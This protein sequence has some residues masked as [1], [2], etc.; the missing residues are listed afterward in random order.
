[1]APRL[2]EANNNLDSVLVRPG[3]GT[4]GKYTPSKR[5]IRHLGPNHKEI[6]STCFTYRVLLRD[7][8]DIP[9]IYGLS[10]Y[11]HIPEFDRWI[12]R[13]V[14]PQISYSQQLRV[15]L[16]TLK[17]EELP[18]ILK[19][20]LQMLVYNGELSPTKVIQL[21]PYARD[22]YARKDEEVA[23]S[24]FQLLQDK[25]SYPN[26]NVEKSEVEIECLIDILDELENSKLLTHELE[27]RPKYAHE[28]QTLIHR[29]TVSPTGIYLSGPFLETKNRVLR[30]FS[31]YADYFLRVEFSEEDGDLVMYDSTADL[32]DIFEGQFKRVLNEG[33][34]IADREF[35]F[36]GFSHSSLRARGCW[37]VAEFFIDDECFNAESIIPK[38]GDFSHITS[39]A[40]YAARIGQTFSDTLTSIAIDP[41]NVKRAPDVIRNDR[42]FSDGCGTLSKEVLW[43]I[44]RQYSLRA[45]V[46]PTVFQI[47][48]SGENSE[49]ISMKH[50]AGL[51]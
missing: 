21:L 49:S 23:R 40:K 41:K 5:R 9:K 38:L 16:N 4:W 30:R 10:S 25:L 36:L 20:Q 28:N 31:S 19:F 8:R 3:P 13:R 18:Y 48:L 35:Q 43:K 22:L 37:F 42:T 2:F 7:A 46:K 34:I 12:D 27:A 45:R 39:P 33:I 15:F 29:A 14:A 47:R 1:M 44:Y 50:V 11:K 51:V 6:V 32:E 26:P 24:V 17:D